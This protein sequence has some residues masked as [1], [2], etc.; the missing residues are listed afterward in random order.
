MNINRSGERAPSSSLNSPLKERLPVRGDSAICIPIRA[1]PIV[2]VTR[3]SEENGK[4]SCVKYYW[5][6]ANAGRVSRWG[7]RGIRSSRLDGTREC[8]HEWHATDSPSGSREKQKTARV[9]VCIFFHH[10]FLP[11]SF[12][13]QKIEREKEI[14][15]RC[16]NRTGFDVSDFMRGEEKQNRNFT[17]A[18]ANPF[19]DL[20]YTK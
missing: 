16:V 9:C 7:W 12:S 13:S 1:I 14:Q 3:M 20:F 2:A 10:L 19:R 18:R 8:T 17:I 15:P 11:L 4:I 6:P 5:R